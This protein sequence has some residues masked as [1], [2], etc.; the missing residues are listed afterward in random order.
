ML[1]L[2]FIEDFFFTL[3]GG[4]YLLDQIGTFTA[5]SSEALGVVSSTIDSVD[6]SARKMKHIPSR[7]DDI[8]IGRRQSV[9]GLKGVPTEEVRGL[10][11]RVWA[12]SLLTNVRRAA[13]LG[14]LSESSLDWFCSLKPTP[15]QQ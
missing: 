9:S 8:L 1:G 11:G 2:R 10:S 12:K 3:G 5:S 14:T 7:E 6:V 13:S 15:K 4:S